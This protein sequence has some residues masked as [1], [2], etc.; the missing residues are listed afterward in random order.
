M[1]IAWIIG[2]I[3]IITTVV[4][5][6]EHSTALQMGLLAIEKDAHAAFV[7]AEKNLH[8]CE[9]QLS[10]ATLQTELNTHDASSAC[11]VTVIDTNA[12][13]ELIRITAVGSALPLQPLNP[14]LRH[15]PQTQLESV[16]YRDKRDHSIKRLSWRVLWSVAQPLARKA[17]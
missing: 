14:N 12:T 9:A 5:H 15:I 16:L 2:L 3:A 10:N 1:I 6:L 17:H 8:Q 13:G 7:A 4:S 11:E